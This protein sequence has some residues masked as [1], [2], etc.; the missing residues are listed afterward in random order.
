MCI[1][2]G[3]IS[4]IYEILKDDNLANYE[5]LEKIFALKKHYENEEYLD[6]IEKGSLIEE[7][8]NVT[9]N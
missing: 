3:Y 8:K 4:E 1:E 6:D 9:Q 2:C 7:D 5:Q